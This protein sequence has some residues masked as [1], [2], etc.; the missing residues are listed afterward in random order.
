MRESVAK[1]ILGVFCISFFHF[2]LVHDAKSQDSGLAFGGFQ[3]NGAVELGYRFTDIDG[4]RN[5]YKEDVNLMQGLRLFDFSL[6]GKNLEP[7]KG[8]VDYFSLTGRDIG[9]PF[10]AARLEVKKNKSYDFTA[11]FNQYHYWSNREDVGWLGDN[12]NFANKFTVETVN[13]S[14][15]PKD[16]FR[17]NLGY[18]HWGRDGEAGVPRENFP[19]PLPQDLDE[20][21]NEYS[22]SADF[23]VGGW[24]F[25]IKES[26]WNFHNQDSIHVPQ[27]FENRNENTNT[28]VS[29]IKAHTRF[30]ERWDFDTALVYAYS[31]G[32]SSINTFPE[33]GIRSGNG[34]VQYDTFVGELGL[35]Y[36]IKKG[37]I[38]HADYRFHTYDQDGQTNTDPF[39]SPSGEIAKTHYNLVAHTG[40]LQLEYLPLNNLTLRGGYQF[41]YQDIDGEFFGFSPVFS[42]AEHPSGSTTQ[43]INGWVGSV[44]WKP[45]NVLNIFGEYKGANTSDPYTW[46]SPDNANIARVKIKY[47]TPLEKLSLNG[48]FSW[49][50]RV[51]GDE[52]YRVDARDYTLAATYQPALLQKLTLDASMTYESIKDH[53][54]IFNVPFSINPFTFTTFNFNSNAWIYSAGITYEGIYKGF[55]ARF[56]GSVA[57]TT[58]E[59]TQDYTDGVL[60]IYYKNK[61][62]TPTLALERTY[63]LDRVNSN[64]SFTANLVTLSLRKEF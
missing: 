40:T 18:R 52:N 6:F 29:T 21:M 2:F 30:G 24:D 56:Y 48:S 44:N 7:G 1:A 19:M 26:F 36:L 42:G 47:D 45:F 28:F 60:S 62:L 4:N 11:S 22:I 54:D 39:L 61:W 5:R 49:R 53:N 57:K 37:L 46:I 64:N 17:L 32:W 16:D 31:N 35:S 13:L 20:G 10:P 55:G 58:G 50:R 43:W 38:L 63:L 23:P 25:H 8:L 3:W 34:N 12:F 33:I 9:D 51:N 27:Y 41:Q 59:N 15:F 14:V